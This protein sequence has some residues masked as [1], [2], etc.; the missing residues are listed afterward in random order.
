MLRIDHKIT[1]NELKS[2]TDDVSYIFVLQA[3]NDLWENYIY[4]G[5]NL[6]DADVDQVDLDDVGH[7]REWCDEQGYF[8]VQQCLPES[9]SLMQGIIKYAIS[10]IE[11]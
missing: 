5:L 2:H 8:F 11:D 3:I 7:F 9:D 6:N 4:N 10:M 1:L